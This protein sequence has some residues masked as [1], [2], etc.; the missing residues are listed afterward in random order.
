M[1]CS[2]TSLLKFFWVAEGRKLMAER[3]SENYLD[4]LLNSVNGEE[5]SAAEVEEPAPERAQEPY[6][7]KS[8]EQ[9]PYEQN[10]FEKDPFDQELFGKQDTKQSMTVKKEEEFMREFEEELLAEEIPDYIKNFENDLSKSSGSSSD[11][12]S[13]SIDS[14]LDHMPQGVPEDPKEGGL[15]NAAPPK[16]ELDRAVDA[17]DEKHDEDFAAQGES[18]NQASLTEDGE[19]DLS[20]MSDSDLMEMLSEDQ[21]LSDLG[22]MLTIDEEGEPIEEG[23]PIGDFAEHEM[24]EQE[25]AV[26]GKRAPEEKASD[27]KKPGFLAKL[28]RVLFGDDDDEEEETVTLKGNTGASASTLSAENEEILKELDEA[29]KKQ[30]TKKA[31]KEKKEKKKKPKPKKQKKPKPKKAPKPKKEKP[32]KEPDNTPQLPKGPVVAIFVMAASLF[33]LVMLITHLL[34]YQANISTAKSL[35]ASGDYVAAYESLQGLTIKDSD[36]ALSNKLHSLAVVTEKYNDYLVFDSYGEKDMALDSLVCAYG[37]YYA[38]KKY[39]GAYEFEEEF[40]ELRGK[41]VASLLSEFNMTEDEALT[42]YKNP[43]R[44]DYTL[45]LREKLKDLGMEE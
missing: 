6:E 30:D 21:D 40:D 41:I 1:W 36:K 11:S 15:P 26:K 19:I 9:N 44:R 45:A 28:K 12:L 27:E 29:G 35:E 8:Y 37:R 22:D 2:I 24:D 5:R 25:K 20:G 7:Q 42:V 34:T 3:G 18:G 10:P 23:D 38:N 31:K 33:G 43:S 16:S 14:L 39:A 13:D 17:F 32:V 4:R